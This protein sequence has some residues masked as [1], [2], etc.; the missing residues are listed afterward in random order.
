MLYSLLEKLKREK[1]PVSV[2]EYLTLLDC[3]NSNLINSTIEDFYFLAKATLIKDE[4][5]FDRFDRIFSDIFKE[6]ENISETLKSSFKIPESWIEK[7]LERIFT[8]KEIEKLKSSGSFEELIDKFKEVFKKQ[9]KRHQG[10]NKWIGTSGTSPFG[11]YGYNPEGIRVG[12][13]KSIHKKAVKVW[14]QRKYK[15][16]D[17]SVE[18][19]TRNIKIALRRLR[20]FAR[21]GSEEKFDIN[22]TIKSTAN[23]AGYLEIKMEK[24]RKNNVKVLLLIDSGGSMDEWI[25][26]CSELFSATKSEFKNLEYYYFHN[27]VYEK[28][29]SSNYLKDKDSIDTLSL[30]NKYSADWKLVFLGDAS[31]S[32]YE[33]LAPGGSIDHWNKQTGEFW[34][35][36]LVSF[37]KRSVWINPIRYEYWEYTPSI[38]IIKK[39]FNEKMFPLNI[40]GIDKAMQELT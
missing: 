25:K 2:R 4:R 32:P 12:Q 13:D 19:G 18:I 24:E 20:S 1:V 34:L 36:K 17:D 16:L 6:H 10:G 8:K 31:M 28:V 33:I 35:K 37:Y 27:C 21:S 40:N 9:E 22:E 26:V 38:N 14:D 39:I 23:N 7:S 15:D 29:W 5:Y 30:I 3:M 11:A